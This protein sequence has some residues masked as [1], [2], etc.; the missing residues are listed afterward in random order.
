MYNVSISRAALSVAVQRSDLVHKIESWKRGK[1]STNRSFFPAVD[2]I[3]SNDFFFSRNS[4]IIDHWP[5]IS[6]IPDNI[7]SRTVLNIT[8]PSYILKS[9]AGRTDQK[10]VSHSYAGK[11]VTKYST[12]SLLG[13]KAKRNFVSPGKPR[14]TRKSWYSENAQLKRKRLP[15]YNIMTSNSLISLRSLIKF[16]HICLNYREFW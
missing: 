12:V 10:L 13:Y 2:P 15:T 16:K 5:N 8:P 4:T 6:N 14:Y 1:F 3:I 11:F 9:R 7:R